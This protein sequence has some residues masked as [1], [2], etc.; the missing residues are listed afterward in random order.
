MSKMIKCKACDKEIAKGVK[1]CVHCGKNQRSFLGRHKVLT[2]ILV[3]IVFVIIVATTSGGKK[4]ESTT[5]SNSSVGS[6]KEDSK[7]NFEN[8]NKINMGSKYE[9]VK[10]LLGEGK[11]LSSAEVSG[12]KTAIYQWNGTGISN[13][14]VTIQNDIV[15]G[16]A[17]MGLKDMDAKITSAK[18]DEVKEGMTYDEV[19]AII[20]E[21]QIL[22]RSKIMD[23]ESV[24]YSWI[25][26]DG[27]NASFTFTGEKL[28]MKAQFNLK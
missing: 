1:K 11:E 24:M 27:S 5:A 9:D 3:V 21:G 23:I 14:N 16:K 10:T 28:Q 26:K 2:G 8:F 20:G 7:V 13:M 18:Y 17:Q 22:S 6:V 15:T 12:I 19:K 25:N 4:S